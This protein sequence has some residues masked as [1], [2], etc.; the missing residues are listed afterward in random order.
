MRILSFIIAIILIVLGL[1]FALLNATPVTLNY[2]LGSQEI[3]LS[4]LLV[5]AVGFGTLIGFIVSIGKILRLKNKIHQQKNRLKQ[6]E[7]ELALGNPQ[8]LKE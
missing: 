3:S 1:T 4:L 2:Y 6:L 7:K 8:L 5:L